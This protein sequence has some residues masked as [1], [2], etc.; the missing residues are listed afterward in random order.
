MSESDIMSRWVCFQ[1][2]LTAQ[3]MSADMALRKYVA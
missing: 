3:Y 2:A 1:P